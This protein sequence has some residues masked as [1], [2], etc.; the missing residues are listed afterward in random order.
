MG[1]T[2]RAEDLRLKG[3]FCAVKEALPDPDALPDEL[4]QSRE[5]FYQEASTLARLDH[6]N[7]PK[8]SDYFSEGNRDYLVMDFVPGQDL[9]EMLTSALHEGHSLSERQVLTWADQLCDALNYLHTQDPPVLHRDIKPSNIKITPAGN[10]KLVDFGLVKLLAPDDQRTIT[11]VQGRG[12]VQYIPLEQYGGD[13]GHTDARSDIYSLGATLYHLLT[14]QPPLDAKQRFLKPR[15]MASPRS[16]NP[17]ISPQTEQAILWSLAMHPDD[18][19]TNVAELRAALLAPSP[20]SRTVARILDRQSPVSQFIRA[21]RRSLALVG[22]LLLAALLLTARPPTLPPAATATATPTVTRSPTANTLTPR[23][24]A[25]LAPRPTA[26]L[27]RRPTVTHTPRPTSTQSPTAP[28][29]TLTLTIT[30]T[31][32]GQ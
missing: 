27:T 17:T 12:T 1:A 6:P 10:V 23:L 30:L 4:K 26:T 7:L 19:P 16:L 11:V 31:P 18:R 21:N 9:K 29:V 14:G 3:R 8:V 20:I 15:A 24:T 13:T 22:V 32:G 5:Q 25:T 28:T 2:Y